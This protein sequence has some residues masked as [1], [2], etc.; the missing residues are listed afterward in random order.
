MTPYGDDAITQSRILKDIPS[1]EFTSPQEITL[2]DGTRA[3]TFESQGPLG[4]M[5]EVWFLHDAYLFELTGY[6][7]LQAHVVEV[8]R[9]WSF[10]TT[11]AQ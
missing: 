1:G 7:E 2:G 6:V 11:T 3:L 4:T 10:S 8:I 5:R 9:T